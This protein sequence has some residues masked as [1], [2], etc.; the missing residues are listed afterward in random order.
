VGEHDEIETLKKY[1]S[2]PVINALTAKF[3]P[4]QI[5]ADLMTLYEKFLPNA[6]SIPSPHPLPLLS[7]LKVAW[8]GDANNILNSML[9]SFPRV[10][11]SLSA[12]CPKEYVCPADVVEYANTNSA[13]GKG[14]GNEHFG[15]V[16]F[17]TE[18]KVA[19][20]NADVIVTDT[21]I[22]MGQEEEME[23]RLKEFQGYK[24]TEEMAALGNSKK[25]WIFMHCLP[26]K[27]YE[28]SDEVFYNPK[29]SVVFQEAEN[30]KYAV[31]SVYKYLYGF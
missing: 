1:S 20:N 29:R 21:W 12:A 8:V 23:K 24:V 13:T 2:V 9:V 19:V 4:L 3:H 16:V 28:V 10:G 7:G 30:R 11:I 18:P 25:D 6:L 26:R 15:K 22:S 27:P 31:M 14:S 17:T 5:I